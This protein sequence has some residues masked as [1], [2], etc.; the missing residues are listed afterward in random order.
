MVKT[1]SE[2]A[3]QFIIVMVVILIRMEEQERDRAM[4][5]KHQHASNTKA[6]KGGNARGDT[7]EA[8]RGA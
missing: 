5:S 3:R 8:I 4:P 6:D 7:S 1:D 2:G